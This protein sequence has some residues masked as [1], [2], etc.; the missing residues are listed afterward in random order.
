MQNSISKAL[1]GDV[2]G[3]SPDEVGA[4]PLTTKKWLETTK[5]AL[6]GEVV[7]GEIE[8]LMDGRRKI[9]RNIIAPIKDDDQVLGIVGMN[10]DISDLKEALEVRDMLLKEV[11]V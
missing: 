5:R 1:W 6:A 10:I 8:Y 2:K 9:Y 4:D 7:K 11:L 3:T